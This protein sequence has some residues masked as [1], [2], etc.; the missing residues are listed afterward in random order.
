MF[1]LIPDSFIFHRKRAIQSQKL[2]DFG[3]LGSVLRLFAQF[4]AGTKK[5]PPLFEQPTK[6]V[7]NC[8]KTAMLQANSMPSGSFSDMTINSGSKVLLPRLIKLYNTPRTCLLNRSRVP[9]MVLKS[10]RSGLLMV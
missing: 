10:N 9:A 8:W 4:H 5:L 3:Q 6:F 7:L 1:D 2:N